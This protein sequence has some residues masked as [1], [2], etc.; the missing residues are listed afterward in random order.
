M[1]EERAFVRHQRALVAAWVALCLALI[2]WPW[3]HL[4]REL[5]TALAG[6]GLYAQYF[7]GRMEEKAAV[8]RIEPVPRMDG[9]VSNPAFGDTPFT[10]LWR[11]LL[12]VP[13][14]GPY[15]FQVEAEGGSL[16]LSVG[17]KEIFNKTQMGRSRFEAPRIRL[18]RG[19]HW[20]MIIW[21][22]AKRPSFFELNWET[23][24]GKLERISSEYLRPHERDLLQVKSRL[25]RMAVSETLARW[26]FL[27][28]GRRQAQDAKRS[29]DQ[30]DADKRR[31]LPKT[32]QTD[33]LSQIERDGIGQ[34][35][36]LGKRPV[37]ADRETPV[38]IK[39]KGHLA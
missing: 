22:A 26:L 9:F 19:P 24:A 31:D 1:P 11:G 5:A 2:L 30:P 36:L 8:G 7:G 32:G 4:H 35:S 37:S 28:G 16:R 17:A 13:E 38:L 39:G 3:I 23:P 6:Q 33:E 20:I 21:R 12:L 27:P 25:R 15:R 14:E 29:Q 18:N 34:E 10:V